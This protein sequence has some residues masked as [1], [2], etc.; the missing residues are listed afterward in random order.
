MLKELV[1][2]FNGT[3]E[4]KRLKNIEQSKKQFLELLN[5]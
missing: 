4:L 2:Y 5:K 1:E 3:T